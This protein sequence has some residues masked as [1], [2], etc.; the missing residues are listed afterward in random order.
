[1]LQAAL[2]EERNLTTAPLQAKRVRNPH[3]PSV[4]LM[5]LQNRCVYILRLV[6]CICLPDDASKH[7]VHTRNCSVV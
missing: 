4:L 2:P 1:M 3:I 5:Y 7:R 6:K